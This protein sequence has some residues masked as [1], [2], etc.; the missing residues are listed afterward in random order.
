MRTKAITASRHTTFNGGRGIWFGKS[1]NHMNLMNLPP[2]S[3]QGCGLTDEELWDAFRT[4][5]DQ[6]A[7]DELIRRYERPLYR[8]LVRYT[9]D[10]DRAEELFQSAFQRVIERRDQFTP[11]RKFR[12]WLY[13]IAMHLAIDAHR[14]SSREQTITSPEAEQ[15]DA[16]Q[17]TLLDLL[18]DHEEGPLEHAEADE[19]RRIIRKAVDA[20]PGDLRR[21]VFLTY[22]QGQTLQE[23]ADTLQL[24]LGTVKSRLHQ[25]L[26]KLSLAAIPPDECDLA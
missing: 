2:S 16:H 5:G 8:Y 12:P 6:G 10:T 19:R 1:I 3:A 17:G 24:P 15:D 20:L 26:I 18:T 4:R 14:H 7:I 13:S 23:V 25:A 11:G 9:G 21:I 22:Y